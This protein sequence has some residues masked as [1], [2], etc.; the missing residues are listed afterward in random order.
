MAKYLITGGCGFIGSHLADQLIQQGHSVVILD[1]LSTGKRENAPR[2]AEVIVA[3][4]T[5]YAAAAYACSNIDGCFHLAAVASVEKSIS[6]WA[7]THRVNITATVNIF[8]AISRLGKK[9]PVVYTSSAAVYGNNPEAPLSETSQVSP[10]TAYGADKFSCELHA[11]IAWLVHQIPTIGLRPFNV[12]GP[13]QD[14]HSPYSG[15]ISIF[16]HKIAQG[17]PITIYGDGEQV[18]DF[19]YV[20]DVARSFATAMERL[21][22]INSGYEVMNVC[23]G[24]ATSINELA[25]IIEKISNKRTMRRYMAARKGDISV[26]IGSPTKLHKY[27]Q[28]P[29][30]TE[31]ENGLSQ[32]MQT[33]PMEKAA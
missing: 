13:R 8:Q 30:A 17:L 5:D 15:V 24:N 20:S 33:L 7:S 21:S 31:L 16:S 28:L 2:E 14:P 27:L 11:R 19:I 6:E 25:D 3:D 26:S 10:L 4:A 29:R 12:Y 9:A 32:L 22:A 1:N 18:R 23:T